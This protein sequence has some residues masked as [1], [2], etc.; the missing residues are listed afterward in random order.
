MTIARY[1]SSS[2]FCVSMDQ[3]EVVVNNNAKKKIYI[4]I[5]FAVLT[6]QVSVNKGFIIWSQ[7]EFFLWEQRGKSEPVRVTNQNSGF[8]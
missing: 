4:Y 1:W 5:Y 6:V 3:V 2:F 7:K 8:A